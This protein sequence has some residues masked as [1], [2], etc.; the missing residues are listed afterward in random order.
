VGREALG[1]LA[2]SG[3]TNEEQFYLELINDA[4]LDPMGDAAKY[5]TSYS[6]LTSSDPDIQKALG[7]RR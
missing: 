7:R 5:L 6:P 2:M 3:P 4:R 1:A